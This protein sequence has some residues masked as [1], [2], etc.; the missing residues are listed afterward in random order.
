MHGMPVVLDDLQEIYNEIEKD[1]DLSETFGYNGAMKVNSSN[2]DTIDHD[3]EGLIVRFQSGRTYRY[4]TADQG[5]FEVLANE[6][7]DANGSVGKTFNRLVRQ[8][9]HEGIEV[10]E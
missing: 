10:T 9:G 4:P 1:I 6:A 8:G 7:T 2:I 5:I 3:R